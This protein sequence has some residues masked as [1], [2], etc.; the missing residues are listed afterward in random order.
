VDNFWHLAVQ[1]FSHYKPLR[2]KLTLSLISGS[3]DLAKPQ[4]LNNHGGRYTTK[5]K[6]LINVE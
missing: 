5:G 4:V 6:G 2:A 3:I 1:T